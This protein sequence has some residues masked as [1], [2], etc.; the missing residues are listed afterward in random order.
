VGWAATTKGKSGP[1]WFLLAILISPILAGIIIMVSPSEAKVAAP[2]PVLG[3]ADELVKLA[4][5][6]DN[7]TITL[8]EFGRQRALLLG[9]TTGAAP[10]STS[11]PSPVLLVGVV[12]VLLLVVG[13]VYQSM[14]NNVNDVL[15]RVGQSIKLPAPAASVLTGSVSSS[16]TGTPF[17]QFR[18]KFDTFYTT[19]VADLKVI[20]ALYAAADILGAQAGATKAASDAGAFLGWLNANP[21][22][23]CYV[24]LYTSALN[25]VQYWSMGA[26]TWESS[27][28]ANLDAGHRLF[29]EA[30]PLI[31]GARAQ[32]AT[33]SCS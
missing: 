14:Q 31:E 13:F 19:G 21:P 26:T 32:M 15:Y 1:T 5:L 6:R 9:S 29:Q 12:V 24:D 25:G 11:G 33:A 7:G 18:A 17:A 2:V 8:E 3:V 28:Q 23:S 10:A 27:T 20:S 4:I 22:Q 30:D 16:Q